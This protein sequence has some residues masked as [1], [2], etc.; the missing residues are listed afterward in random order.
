MITSE[1][2]GVVFNRGHNLFEREKY[3]DV[4]QKKFVKLSYFS[5]KFW[6]YKQIDA[7]IKP[8]NSNPLDQFPNINGFK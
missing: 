5:N 4:D 8:C 6:P 2:G 3:T 7:L 1:F